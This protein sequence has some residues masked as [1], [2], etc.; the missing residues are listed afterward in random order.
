MKTF[1]LVAAAA[2]CF[3]ASAFA[4]NQPDQQQNQTAK[5]AGQD[6]GMPVGQNQ[7]RA[8]KFDQLDTNDNGSISKSEASAS[9]EFLVI[10]AEVDAN[11]E[12]AIRERRFGPWGTPAGSSELDFQLEGAERSR[13]DASRRSA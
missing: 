8:Q 10:W 2:L 6:S 13:S 9:P 11:G 7:T 5:P 3:T 1:S 12:V 4:Q